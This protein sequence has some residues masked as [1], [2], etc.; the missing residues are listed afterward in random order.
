M[1]VKFALQGDSATVTILGLEL[2]GSLYVTVDL[3]VAR[4]RAGTAV[5]DRAVY[6][7]P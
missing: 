4:D 2:Y 3:Q 6:H 7:P 5:I 1:R